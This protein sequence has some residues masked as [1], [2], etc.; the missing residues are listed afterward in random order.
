M[1]S[2]DSFLG[3]RHGPEA[4]ID[5]HTLVVTLLS[6]DPYKRKYEEELLEELY[7][8]QLGLKTL[9]VVS[10]TNKVLEK[11]CDYI[12]EYDPRGTLHLN[13]NVLAPVTVIPG[14]LLGLFKSLEL[15]LRPD[16]PSEGGVIH[17]VVEGVTIYDPQKYYRNNQ[18]DIVAKR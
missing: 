1:C 3:L 8:K 13:D 12:L 7:K 4:V 18:F 10:K 2:F 17:R 16:N 6:E 11:T 5:P 15:G 14:Q 9:A